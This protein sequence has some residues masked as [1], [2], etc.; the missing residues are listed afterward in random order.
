[1]ESNVALGLA[2][3]RPYQDEAVK[4]SVERGS[5]LLALTMGAGK[6]RVAID[7]IQELFSRED[8]GL[9][10][11]VFCTSSL[12]FQWEAEIKKWW[13]GCTVQVIDGTK[14]KRR[15]QYKEDPAVFTILSYEMLIHDWDLLKQ[16]L[17]IDFIIADEATAIKGFK[18]KRSKRMKSMGKHAT[19][20]IA[21]SGLP[22]EN[23]PEELY[24]IMEFVDP[25][26]LGPFGKFDRTFITRDHWG[27]PS[28]YKNL[29]VLRERMTPAIVRKSRK[30][31]EEFLPERIETELPVHLDARSFRVYDYIR[32]DLLEVL[33]EMVASGMGGFDILAH[34]GKGE[35]KSSNR[36]KGEVMSR[37]TCM[38]L[39]C[40]DP[41]LL[42]QSAELYD[43]E[44]SDEGSA[45]ASFL[46]EEGLLKSLPKQ[47]AKMAA[48]VDLM[49]EIHAQPNNKVVVFSSYKR[50]I[51]LLCKQL[52][53]MGIGYTSMTGDTPSKVR[54]ERMDKF[55]E[56]PL[57]EVF[58]SSDSG[59]YGINL[60]KGSHLISFDL[61]WSAG[62]LEQRVARIDRTSSENEQ[63]DLIYMYTMGTVEERQYDMLKQKS[64]IA[65]A[66]LDGDGVSETGK[67]E[68]DLASLRTYLME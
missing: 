58:L 36:L 20:R 50:Q 33:D 40:N 26:V 48:F 32:R 6:T 66:F 35:D 54:K 43:S 64:K 41:S 56:H 62:A 53:D 51:K 27:S 10:G 61:P 37:I 30:D 21:L 23:K 67:L 46:K 52:K 4:K 39:L 25:E 47:S 68:L 7:T 42:L 63:I 18:A 55:Q 5:I 17:P 65:G 49:E 38:K 13:P 44:D 8:A 9:Y 2:P 24:S 14:D 60:D 31:I 57:I 29:H 15:V 34:Y 19:Y 59:T 28:Q 11:A 22:V 16:Y 1:M 12:K 45:Y 3:R